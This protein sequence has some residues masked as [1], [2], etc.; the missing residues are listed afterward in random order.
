MSIGELFQYGLLL[1]AVVIAFAISTA[2]G[3]LVASLW[4]TPLPLGDA[5]DEPGLWP[6]RSGPEGEGA[7]A[8]EKVV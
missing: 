7:E 8:L 1:A 5:P 2:V 6:R 3:M 4:A